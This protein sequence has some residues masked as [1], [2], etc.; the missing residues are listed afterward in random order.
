MSF[1]QKFFVLTFIMGI[2]Y[3]ILAWSM[4]KTTKC[5]KCVLFYPPPPTNLKKKIVHACYYTQFFTK[6]LVETKWKPYF[7]NNCKNYNW[8]GSRRGGG[9]FRSFYFYH[10]FRLYIYIY[11]TNQ[12]VIEN[13]L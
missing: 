7:F 13:F 12:N 8:S 11:N 1:L 9:F 2:F 5:K 6:Q 10:Y 3:F 4:L